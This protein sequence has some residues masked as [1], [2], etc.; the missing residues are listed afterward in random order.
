MQHKFQYILDKA[1]RMTSSEL[2]FALRDIRETFRCNKQHED[3]DT[4][5]G[6]KLWFEFDTYAVTLQRREWTGAYK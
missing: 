2:E 3:G 1:K 6:Q 4:A 5:Y